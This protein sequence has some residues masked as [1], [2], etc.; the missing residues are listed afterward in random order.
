L[1]SLYEDRIG[2]VGRAR[3]S[4]AISDL[5]WQPAQAYG[6]ERD[7]VR[8]VWHAGHVEAL[9]SNGHSV[10]AGSQTG[11]VWVLTPTPQP[12]FIAGHMG[13]PLSDLWDQPD[14]TSLA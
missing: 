5:A 1:A 11:G 8:T 14:V 4:R 7:D 13:T 6:I 9:L 12:T 10:I 2:A 3:A